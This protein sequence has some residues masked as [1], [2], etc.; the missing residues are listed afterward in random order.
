MKITAGWFLENIPTWRSVVLPLLPERPRWLEI[1]S[2]EGLS[3]CWTIE[4]VPG[5]RLVCVDVW[6][7]LPAKEHFDYNVAGRA[8]VH[9]CRS[10]DYLIKATPYSF[11]VVYIDGDHEAKSV[12]EDFVLAWPLVAVGGIIIFDDYKWKMSGIMP[13]QPAIDALLHIYG[14]RIEVLHKDRQV[15]VKKSCELRMR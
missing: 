4:N 12:I 14:S 9:H 1:G 13:P 10:W 2:H 8:E 3:A 7:Y 15:I 5:V 11:D 6:D